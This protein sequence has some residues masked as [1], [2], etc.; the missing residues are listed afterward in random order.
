MQGPAIGG[1]SLLV[2]SLI[3][4]EVGNGRMADR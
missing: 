2:L 1:A 3:A 4:R